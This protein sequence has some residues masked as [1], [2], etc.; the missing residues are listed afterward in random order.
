TGR[1]IGNI[2]TPPAGGCRTSIDIELDGMQDTLDTKGFHQ[3]IIYGNLEKELT[4][5]C[6]LSGINVEHI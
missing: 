6:R 1:V 5:Y 4:A 2:D 3:I